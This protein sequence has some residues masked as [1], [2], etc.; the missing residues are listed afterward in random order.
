LPW[1]QCPVCRGISVQ[2][3]VESVSSLPWNGCPVCSGIR[4]LS[5]IHAPRG[6]GKTYLGLSIGCSVAAGQ[7][8]FGWS[9]VRSCKVHYLDGEMSSG[10]LQARLKSIPKRM[11]PVQGMFKLSTPDFQPGFLPDLCTRAGQ[12]MINQGIAADTE[13]IIVDNLSSWSKSGREDSEAWAPI[14]EWALHHRAEGRSII[15]VHHSGKNGSQRGTS[16][17]ED[18]LDVVLGLRRP[19]NYSPDEGASFEIHFEKN[20]HLFGEDVAPVKVKL[21]KDDE[22]KLDWE[23]NAVKAPS[24]DRLKE[25][26]QLKSKGLNQSEIAKKLGVDRATVSRAL[27]KGK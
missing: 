12:D 11:R 23:W 14:A 24:N 5:M 20:R 2:F 21:V 19:S 16:R 3:A 8:L 10:G 7:D 17:K 13:L 25:I 27:K 4:T 18:L 9:C 26:V 15:F 1:N 22:G 6:V